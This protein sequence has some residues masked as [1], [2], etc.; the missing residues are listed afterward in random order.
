MDFASKLKAEPMERYQKLDK[1]GEGTYG[2]VYK[3]KDR[4]SDEANL[5]LSPLDRR[6]QEN[7]A[8]ERGGRGAV[9]GDKGDS[10]A[11]GD[12]APQHRQVRCERLIAASL[13]DIV[14]SDNSLYLIFEYM[15]YDLKKF[16]QRNGPLTPAQVKVPTCRLI[17]F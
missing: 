9:D 11:E 14:H 8:G 15:D 2:I 1:L 3:A 7:Q 16:V 12:K 10:A 4:F 6:P 5:P 17:H 13:K